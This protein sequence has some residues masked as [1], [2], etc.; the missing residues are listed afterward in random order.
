VKRVT[1][2]SLYALAGLLGLVAVLAVTAWVVAQTRWFRGQVRTRIVYELENATGGRVELGALTLNPR[3]LTAEVRNLVIHGTEGPDQAPLFR[4]ASIQA[5]LKIISLLKRQIDIQS[6]AVS[7]PE[8]HLI[9]DEKG[10]TNL[11]APKAARKPNKHPVETILDLAIRRFQLIDGVLRLETSSVPLNALGENLRA[12]VFYETAGPRY[13][14]EISFRQLH[15]ASG[16]VKA[17]PCDLDAKFA[18]E[19]NRLELSSLRL[20]FGDSSVDASGRLEDFSSPRLALQYTA[21]ARLK[22]L[23]PALGLAALPPRGTLA[24]SGNFSYSEAAGSALTGKLEGRGL[25]FQQ[26]GIR[27]ENASLASEVALTPEKLEFRNL[28]IS[29]L[30]GRV[31]GRAEL[32]KFRDFA[33]HAEVKDFSLEELTRVPGVRSMPWSG[34][35]SGPVQVSGR[36]LEGELRVLSASARLAVAP[37]PGL[38]PLEGS[39]DASY[40]QNGGAISLDRSWLATRSSRLQ[41]NGTLG[42]RLEVGLQSADLR[43]FEPAIAMLSNGPVQPLPLRLQDGAARFQGAVTGPLD[44]PQ[45]QGRLRLTRFLLEGRSFDALEADLAVSRRAAAVSNLSLE[46]KT[47]RLTGAFK[48]GLRDWEPDPSQPLSGDLSLRAPNLTQLLA[49]AGETLPVTGDLEGRFELAGTLGAPQATGQITLV[50]GAAYDQPFDRFEAGLR[51]SEGLLEVPSAHLQI[52]PSQV[53]LAAAF[54]HPKT[55]WQSGRLRLE[56]STKGFPLARL[57]PAQQQYPGLEGRIEGQLTAQLALAGREFRL[58]G[59]N[60]QLALAALGVERQPL[61]DL[62]LTAATAGQLLRV[63]LT[64][65]LIGS[66]LSGA[67]QWTLQQSYPAEGHLEFTRLNI[68]TLVARLGGKAGQE[69]PFDGFAAGRAAFSGAALEPQ[70]WR[71]ALNLQEVEII[72]PPDA[73][74]AAGGADINL[75]NDGEVLLDISPKLATIRRARLAGKDTSLQVSG[76]VVF[77]SRNPWNLRIQGTAN[78]GVL[79]SFEPELS[80][81][82]RLLLDAAVRGPLAQPELYGRAEIQDGA[83]YLAGLSNGLDKI[84][85]VAFLYRDRATIERFTAETGGGRVT[86]AGFVGLGAPAAYYLQATAEQVRYRD[87]E[88]VSLTLN[89]AVNLTGTTERSVLGGEAT[90]TRISFNPRTDLGSLLARSAQPASAPS[91]PGKFA[92]GIRLDVRVRTS[93]QARL[94]TALT[95]GLQAQA[96][97]RLR[98]DPMRPVLLGRV[99]INQGDVLFFGNKYAIDSGEITSVNPSRTDPIV[100]L[101]LQTKV[102]G[103]D[104]TLTLS[105]PIDK[106]NVSYRSD[107]PLPLSDIVGLLATGREPASSPGLS[108]SRSALSQS[109]EQAGASAIMSQAIASPLVGRLQRLFGVSSLKIDPSLSGTTNTPEARLTLEQQISQNLVFTYITNLTR[110]QEQTIRV[111]WGF[112]KHWSVV[113]LREENGLFGIDFLYRRRFK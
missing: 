41:F 48:A 53:Q 3:T 7:K 33:V 11:P 12:Q 21:R 108:G 8:V 35:L 64:G 57:H 10:S 78:L 69:L 95:R 51:Y 60:G 47:M 17:L 58:T 49:E 13:R 4:A 79:R 82:G 65:A 86:V 20:G 16:A 106:L 38:N 76:S 104:V 83:L 34:T 26:R 85:A 19:K 113:G 40:N 36:L 14:G 112:A 80:A 73:T 110:A 15:L 74:A 45:V 39:I 77:G 89:A 103:I 62:R 31:S 50:K 27:I 29:A 75:R 61:G 71:A 24:L 90:I 100:N 52:G 32:L 22:D 92:Q 68:G 44:D 23:A 105:G 84:S 98:G 107:P 70:S 72:P 5:G 42:R 28:T 93:P 67:S 96:D 6:L 97:L 88:G 94:E 101:D 9:I 1:K 46:K 30:G 111:E 56:L 81:S 37:A 2:F 87:P 59:L 43:D 66:K 63:N 18:L 25:A 99:L 55:G 91:H 102:R 109:W 54:E